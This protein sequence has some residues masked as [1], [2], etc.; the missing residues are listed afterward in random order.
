MFYGD[1]YFRSYVFIVLCLGSVG[2][3][4]FYG[5]CVCEIGGIE[6]LMFPRWLVFVGV[7]V[8]AFF[9]SVCFLSGCL[10]F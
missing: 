2:F 7:C 9:C 1:W 3:S 10:V 8:C 5:L 4:D 6:K